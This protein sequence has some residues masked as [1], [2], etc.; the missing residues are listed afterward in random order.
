MSKYGTVMVKN[1]RYKISGDFHRTIPHTQIRDADSNR[2]LGIT[3]PGEITH[4]HT[5]G[6]EAVFFQALGQKMIYGTRCDDPECESTAT[7]YLPF[8]SHCPDCLKKN[9]VVDLTEQCRNHARIHTFMVCE[10]AGAFNLLKEPVKFIDV[11]IQGVAT[12]LMSYLSLGEP[13]IG[14]R[15]VP[16]FKTFDPDCSILDLS[17]VPAGTS[18]DD[19]PTGFEL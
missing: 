14:M 15:V 12:I 19:I 9:S 11:E 8:R 6:S 16:I 18:R 3:N 4:I 1:G 2:L 10:R 17:W 7:V 13:E 5:Y